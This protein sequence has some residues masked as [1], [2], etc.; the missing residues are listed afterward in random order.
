[1]SCF[2]MSM[3]FVNIIS[4]DRSYQFLGESSKSCWTRDLNDGGDD[5]KLRAAANTTINH[6]IITIIIY[7]PLPAI[8][9]L[10]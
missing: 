5:W 10:F 7:T 4:F 9:K 6:N 1:M 8:G 3:R 2:F